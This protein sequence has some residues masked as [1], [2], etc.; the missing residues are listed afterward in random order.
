MTQECTPKRPRLCTCARS[1]LA[2][3]IEAKDQETHDHLQQVQVYATEIGKELG[4]SASEL[5]ALRAAAL[6]HDIG[7]IAVPDHII[8]KPGKLTPEEFQKMKIHPVVGAEILERVRFPFPVAPVVR[9]HHEKWDGSGYPAGLK[10]EE[11]PIGS[12]ILSAVDCLDALASN[13][14]YRRALPLNEAMAILERESGKAFDP[15]V[16]EVL[17]RRYIEL[18]ELARNSPLDVWHLSTDIH[19]ERGAAPAAGFADVPAAAAVPGSPTIGEVSDLIRLKCLLD[20]VNSGERFLGF[21][22]TLAIL[23]TRLASLVTFDSLAVYVKQNGRLT[24]VYAAG[25]HRTA[26]A[27]LAIP[28]GHGASGWAAETGFPLVNGNMAV[29]WCYSTVPLPGAAG[30]VLAMPLTGGAGTA[31]VLTLYSSS[32]NAFHSSDQEVLASFAPQLAQYL[33][34]NT[35]EA[36]AGAAG[37]DSLAETLKQGA[38]QVPVAPASVMIH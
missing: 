11:I 17:K 23:G 3:A 16:V 13:R 5:E 31:G 6:L 22:E 32:E 9:C 25:D 29:E 37:S 10:G 15:R 7:K 35:S 30:S 36:R 34:K 26:I 14:H 33:D 4:L 20:A 28:I 19:I 18:E 21:H 24:P 38:P 2:L 8:T 12:R 27:S 1:S